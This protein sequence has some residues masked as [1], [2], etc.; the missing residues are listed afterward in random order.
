MGTYCN[1]CQKVGL[2]TDQ[3]KKDFE[4]RGKNLFQEDLKLAREM[5]VRGFPTM[6]FTNDA[7]K[8][9]LFTAQNLMHSTK[10][11]F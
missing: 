5:G 4:G 10:L 9:R 8:R 3:L 6:F 7:G 2:N 11:L 1:S